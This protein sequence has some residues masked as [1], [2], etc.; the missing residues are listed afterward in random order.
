M[1]GRISGN[2]L[3]T[4]PAS[5]EFS[6]EPPEERLSTFDNFADCGRSRRNSRDRALKTAKD[7]RIRRAAGRAFV[8]KSL[9]IVL[10]MLAAC[11]LV[12]AKEVP[13]PRAK[14]VSAA[15][16]ASLAPVPEVLPLYDAEA[17]PSDCALR[18]KEIARFAHQPSLNGP[19]QCGA[20]DVVR[21]EGLVM[22]NSAVVSIMP[23][24]T[25]GCP[26]AEAVA[27]WVR[28]DLGPAMAELESPP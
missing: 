6:V 26:I 9:S 25:L 15:H 5:E 8:M 1:R 24:A 28:N 14:P 12:L 27:Q 13:R 16:P 2:P 10:F 3:G 20:S 23:A 11:E 17:W 19:G 18:L 21:L 7:L 22:P 4:V